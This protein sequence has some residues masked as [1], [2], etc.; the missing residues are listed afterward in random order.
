MPIIYRQRTPSFSDS[1]SELE[2]ENIPPAPTDADD[3]IVLSDLVRTG[4]AS[5]LRRRGAMRLDHGYGGQGNP[6]RVFNPTVI[7]VG[8]PTW[9]SEP[10]DSQGL[11][12][13]RERTQRYARGAQRPRRP[14]EECESD[15]VYTLFCGGEESGS[16]DDSDARPCRPYE[17]SVLPLYPPSSSASSSK[18][19][20]PR[21]PK[22]SNGCG[23]VLH[24][25]AAP[26]QR[27]GTWSAKGNASSAVVSLDECYFDRETASKIVRSRC[28]CIREG[29]GCAVCGN[30]LG[31]RFR[32][33]KD[34]S[35][36]A[37]NHRP[38]PS[39]PIHPEG[40]RY[41][42]AHGHPHS[43]PHKTDTYNFTFL[44]AMVSS[45]PAYTFPE[46]QPSANS[47]SST[48]SMST[49]AAQ[50]SRDF[51]VNDDTSSTYTNPMFDRIM[52]TSPSPLSD[53][54]EDERES[55]S[56]VQGGFLGADVPF[57]MRGRNGELN[58]AELDPDGELIDAEPPSPKINE[59]MLFA[60]R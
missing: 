4:E 60:E 15:V 44:P 17:P 11:G 31:T 57:Y 58:Y 13:S 41:W 40:P 22:R 37:V 45:Y 18:A 35:D 14:T 2:N 43:H 23:A 49:R 47:Y 3:S 9:E 33:C 39:G 1:D 38:K 56:Q 12:V 27:Q 16:E 34:A 48:S 46:R 50:Q 32:P 28:G 25:S 19:R 6:P 21:K 52:T 42:R 7:V 26:R 24:M 30:P 29:V 53:V 8:S 59:V 5:R 55:S 54:G 36:G 51:Y 10:E 20:Y